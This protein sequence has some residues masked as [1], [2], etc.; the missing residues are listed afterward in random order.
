MVTSWD[1]NFF[2]P[3]VV[4]YPNLPDSYYSY[5]NPNDPIIE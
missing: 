2:K 3:N 4:A 1:W 5:P